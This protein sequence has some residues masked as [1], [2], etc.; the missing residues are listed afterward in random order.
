MP[1]TILCTVC[2]HGKVRSSGLLPARARYTGSHIAAVDKIAQEQQLPFYVLSGL[3]GLIDA[4]EEVPFYDYLLQ[5]EDVDSL[6][7]ALRMQIEQGNILEV[8][9]YV[10]E[11]PAWRP[12]LQALQQATDEMHIYFELHHLPDDA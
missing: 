10:K 4:E 3:Y 9:L 11:R 12:Y 5:P 6:V 2:S 8:H 7:T 1:R